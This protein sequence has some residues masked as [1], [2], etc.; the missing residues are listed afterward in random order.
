MFIAL[1]V[2]TFAA[3]CLQFNVSSLLPAYIEVEYPTLNALSVGVLM[4]IFP[5]GYLMTTPFIGV[6]QE[7]LGRKNIIILGVVTIT[8]ATL[9]FGCASY[10]KNV[11]VFYSVSLVARLMQGIA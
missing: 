7:K 6:Y 8:L 10:F 3:M 11:W 9:A 4:S 5:A 1:L 2:V